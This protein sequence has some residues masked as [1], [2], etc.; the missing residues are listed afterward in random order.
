MTV[1]E[2]WSTSFI[3][4]KTEHHQNGKATIHLCMVLLAN[5]FPYFIQKN[6]KGS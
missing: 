4:R 1:G 3:R 6:V 2:V 5:T